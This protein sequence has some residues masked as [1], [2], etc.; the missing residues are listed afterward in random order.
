MIDKLFNDFKLCT[1]FNANF[2]CYIKCIQAISKLARSHR[3]HIY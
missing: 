2:N 1:I 3:N